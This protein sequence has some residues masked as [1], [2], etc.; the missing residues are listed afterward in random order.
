MIFLYWFW[1]AEVGQTFTKEAIVSIYSSDRIQI[2]DW[3]KVGS[4]QSCRPFWSESSTLSFCSALSPPSLSSLSNTLAYRYR[5]TDGQT[6]RHRQT[7]RQTDRQHTHTK[8]SLVM[9]SGVVHVELISETADTPSLDF[10]PIPLTGVSAWVGHNH[11][12]GSP[13]LS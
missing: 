1:S 8:L 12:P 11:W 10:G 13:I 5:E 7:D 4:H 3:Q 9:S 2:A 6:D